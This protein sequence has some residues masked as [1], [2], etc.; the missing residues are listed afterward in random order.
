LRAVTG[1]EIAAAEAVSGRTHTFRARWA[2]FLHRQAA[3]AIFVERFQCSCCVFK[4]RSGNLAVAISIEGFDDRRWAERWAPFAITG[5]T[6][7]TTA[8]ATTWSAVATL[9][10]DLFATWAFRAV[11]IGRIS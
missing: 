4:F 2:E 11:F 8:W 6:G 5:A 1:A 7:T 10:I 9:A 3:V